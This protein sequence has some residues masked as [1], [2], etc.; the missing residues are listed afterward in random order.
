MYEE[1]RA[2]LNKPPDDRS[3]EGKNRAGLLQNRPVYHTREFVGTVLEWEP[4]R[5][6]YWAGPVPPGT[7][8]TGP[9]STGLRTLI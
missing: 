2:R 1:S 7:V 5:F 3:R 9:V 4:D 8:R 6:V